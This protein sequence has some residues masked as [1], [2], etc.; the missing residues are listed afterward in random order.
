M[1]TG[2]WIFLVVSWSFVLG[3]MF[4]SFARIL[5]TQRHF[6]PDG[7]GPAVPPEP[8]ATDRGREAAEP[9]RV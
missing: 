3:L 4:W 1:S 2:A 6:D 9:H 7:I 5:K 8:A